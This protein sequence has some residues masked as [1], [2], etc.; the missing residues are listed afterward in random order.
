VESDEWQRIHAPWPS[1]VVSGLNGYQVSEVFHPYTCDAHG[2][3][4]V[5][6][7]DGWRCPDVTKGGCVTQR[8]AWA[9][10]A[11]GDTWRRLLREAKEGAAE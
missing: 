11:D 1:T 2:A 10:T 7:P 8:W 9:W 5:A 6:T 3:R 4:L